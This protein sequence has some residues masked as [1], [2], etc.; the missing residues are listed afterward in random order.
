MAFTYWLRGFVK[1]SENFESLQITRQEYQAL[2]EAKRELSDLVAIE[3]TFDQFIEN[4]LEYEEDILSLAQRQLLQSI[5]SWSEG[6]FETQRLNRRVAN[7]LTSAKQ[8]QDLV[9]RITGKIRIGQ[10]F[11]LTLWKAELSHQ[12]DRLLGHRAMALLRNYTQ[13]YASPI[14]L[15]TSKH[16]WSDD[17]GH[18]VCRIVPFIRVSD[19]KR[20]EKRYSASGRETLTELAAIGESVPLTPLV[21]ESVEGIGLAHEKLRELLA[22]RANEAKR[23]Y[24]DEIQR[25]NDAHSTNARAVT[26]VAMNAN[27]TPADQQSIF[28]DIVQHYDGLIRKNR[29]FVSFSVR[30]VTGECSLPEG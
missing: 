3:D 28:S 19:L 13:H 14:S 9:E 15:V 24:S 22:A 30:H 16:G 7:V 23:L 29:M 2:L 6:Q 5:R 18:N 11:V 25:F 20:N 12:Y 21:R 10:S 4:Y 27:G 8:Y 1:E 17:N 26:L